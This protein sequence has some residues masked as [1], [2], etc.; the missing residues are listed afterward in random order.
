MDLSRRDKAAMKLAIERARAR[1]EGRAQQIDAKLKAEP[2]EK[3]GRFAA[4][5]CQY[6]T[7]GL[8]PWQSSPSMIEPTQIAAIVAAPDDGSGKRDAALLLQRML[9][10]RISRWH[11]DPMTALAAVE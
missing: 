5:S 10:A 9:K 1:D 11:P 4:Y 6:D 2:F 7:L 3:V 8:K